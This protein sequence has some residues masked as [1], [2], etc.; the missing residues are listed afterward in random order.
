MIENDALAN[1][2]E[3]RDD[4]STVC[5]IYAADA[6]PTSS[7]F[8][9]ND[10]LACYATVGGITFMG[11][12]YVRKIEKF[13][14]IKT[15]IADD[16]VSTA[17]VTFSNITGEIADFEFENGFE[18]LV[19]V[20]RL[21]SRAASTALNLSQILFTGRCDKPLKGNARS[22]S[23]TA[24]HV[25][26]ATDVYIP[27]RT[28]GPEDYK[29]RATSDP[30]NEGFPYM[31]QYGTTAFTRVEHRGGFLGLWN[32]KH[33]QATT[34]WTNF[35]IEDANKSVPEVIGIIQMLGIL[36]AAV[37]I[38]AY[39]NMRIAFCEGPIEA[40]Q[41]YAYSTN[42]AM[43]LNTLAYA[44]QTGEVGAANGDDPGWIGG[45]WYYSRTAMLRTQATNANVEEQDPPPGVAAI[46]RGRLIAV[47]DDMGDWAVGATASNNAAAALRHFMTDTNYCNLDE[48]WIAND[49][50]VE[51]FSYNAE[52]LFNKSFS[53]FVFVEEG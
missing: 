27:R 18:G 36:V 1:I 34:P 44:D 30:E 19:L 29:G 40:I 23:V 25:L 53:D 50:A 42:T 41:E 5:E 39:V 51:C 32:R 12:D 17:Q 22:L 14:S 35:S 26:G 8:D 47:P 49:D 20:V 28:F 31:P 48:N 3:T 10:A 52:R 4:F 13:G 45:P 33:V 11:V 16:D 24:R 21:I 43:P 15:T 38:G 46:V 7:G 37:D 6:T 2:L 9:P